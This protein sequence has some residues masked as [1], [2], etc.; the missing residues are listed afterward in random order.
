[1]ELLRDGS[2]E[3]PLGTRSGDYI[4]AAPRVDMRW[5]QIGEKSPGRLRAASRSYTSALTQATA[6]CRKLARARPGKD[7]TQAGEH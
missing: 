1:M 6:G 7:I 2:A 5:P 4:R 3:G